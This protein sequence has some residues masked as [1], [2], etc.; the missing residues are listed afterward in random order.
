MVV[1]QG[2]PEC[3]VSDASTL[4]VQSHLVKY[5]H[6][7]GKMVKGILIIQSTSLFLP[8]SIVLHR[9]I[10]SIHLRV[11]L[12]SE[13]GDNPH[14]RGCKAGLSAAS[15]HFNYR[16]GCFYRRVHLTF[17]SISR[18][19]EWPLLRDI[20]Y[21]LHSHD[22]LLVNA[23]NSAF[24]SDEKFLEIIKYIFLGPYVLL[25]ATS[26]VL[27]CS[28]DASCLPAKTLAFPLTT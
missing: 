12:F 21:T 27:W 26:C 11:T 6:S 7:D 22:K 3:C 24:V 16:T 8:P 25:Q 13:H 28:Q 19:P 10:Y 4:I 2:K 14:V 23:R 9:V 5:I 18:K 17:A 15:L 1:A 20:K